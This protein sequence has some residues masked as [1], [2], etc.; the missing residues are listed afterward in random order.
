[1]KMSK[2]IIAPIILTQIFQGKIRGK[3]IP[4]NMPISVNDQVP[5]YHNT[6]L[7]FL[8]NVNSLPKERK[9]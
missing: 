3:A 6:N 7:C 4:I 8:W 1:M 5:I 2:L 9:Y